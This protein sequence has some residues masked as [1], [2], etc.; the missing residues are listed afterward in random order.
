MLFNISFICLQL[1]QHPLPSMDGIEGDVR[2]GDNKLASAI[3]RI[4]NQNSQLLNTVASTAL[5]KACI[6][7]IQ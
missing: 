7:I 3:Y 5:D 6:L 4:L 1:Q 2:V